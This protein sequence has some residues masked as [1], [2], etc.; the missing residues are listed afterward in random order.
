M[1]QSTLTWGTAVLIAVLALLLGYTVVALGDAVD[2]ERAAHQRQAQ[3]KQLALD[4]GDASD[5]LTAEARMFAITGASSHLDAYWKE[6]N[7]TKTR[8]RVIEQLKALGAPGELFDLL[9]EAKAKSDALVNTET[10][11]MRLV[12]EAKNTPVSAMPGPVGEFTLSAADAALS[13]RAKMA[14]AGLIMS[15]DQYAAD[16]ALITTPLAKFQ[17]KLEAAAQTQVKDATDTTGRLLATLLALTITL[18]VGMA[19]VLVLIHLKTGRTVVRYAAALR[20]RDPR[21]LDFALPPEGTTE[22]RELAAGFNSQ[23]EQVRELVMAVRGSADE[24]RASAHQLT[25]L[26]AD[27]LTSSTSATT[28]TAG[29]SAA[30]DEV[31]HNVA[32]VSAGVEQMTASIGEISQNASRAAEVASSAVGVAETAQ[33]TANRLGESSAEINS[34]VTLINGIAEQTNLLALNATIEA[35]RAGEAGKGFAVVASE[36]KDLAQETG[37]A[38]GDITSRMDAIQADTAAVIAAIA[39]ISGIIERISDSQNTIASA[40]EEQTAT[41]SEISRSLGEAAGGSQM[42]AGNTADVRQA[43]EQ[44]RSAANVTQRACDELSAKAAQLHELVRD[45]HV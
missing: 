37:R 28:G 41:T 5:L 26:S 23:F 24:V 44:A 16:K 36:V 14:R 9:A 33:Q 42:I 40:V 25:G 19:A 13:P 20:H 43:S 2:D 12:L 11:A 18:A 3:F 6:I 39:E 4:L 32:A 45:Y 17:Q 27:L 22:L 21:N 30:A 38:T 1:K 7:Q 15:D 29:V 10:R 31:S 34:V 35:A 8:D